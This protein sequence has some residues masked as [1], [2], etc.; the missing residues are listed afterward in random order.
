M[1]KRINQ[2]EDLLDPEFEDM[3]EDEVGKFEDRRKLREILR[4]EKQIEEDHER[5][6]EEEMRQ[7]RQRRE[8]A[9]QKEQEAE[10]RRIRKEREALYKRRR[11]FEEFQKVTYAKEVGDLPSRLDYLE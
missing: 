1:T 7:S 5:E 4:H 6:R 2:A 8:E 3:L 9:F 10:Q 11:Q